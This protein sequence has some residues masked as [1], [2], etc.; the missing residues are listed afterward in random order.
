MSY[1]LELFF[2]PAVQRTRLLS[3]FAARKHHAVAD[4]RASYENPDTGVYFS[5]MLRCV[6]NV[7]FRKSVAAVEFEINYN[8]P[9]FF[10]IEAE[11]EISE[12]VAA[13][14][15]ARI[16][17]PQIRGMAEGPYSGE[18]F[19]N[20]WN[21]GNLFSIHSRLSDNPDRDIPSMAAA[22]LHASCTWNYQRAERDRLNVRCFVPRIMFSRIKERPRRVIVWPQGNP[23]LLPEADYVLV[24][25][26]AGAEK[27]YGL[28]TWSEV[29]D[30]VQ[31]AGFDT[32]RS[33]LNL[34]YAATPPPIAHWVNNIPLIDHASLSGAKMEAYQVVDDELVAAARERIERDQDNLSIT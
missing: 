29:L 15:P 3:Y 30:V 28:A 21:F 25:R 2:D 7:V 17:D 12:L 10:G 34:D 9:S 13:F 22:E 20:G 23:V 6:R 14:Q 33:P 8:R 32:T 5:V 27:R 1:S 11:R 24:G 19:L 26:I 4:A 31:R 18:G 16:E